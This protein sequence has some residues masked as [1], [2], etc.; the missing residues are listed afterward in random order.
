MVVAV[1]LLLGAKCGGEQPFS[2]QGKDSSFLA[3]FR[4]WLQEKPE[5]R[6]LKG[7]VVV[8]WWDAMNILAYAHG[9]VHRHVMR[10]A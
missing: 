5:P 6:G 7:R 2:L 1:L 9:I 4:L 10:S 3:L 8:D